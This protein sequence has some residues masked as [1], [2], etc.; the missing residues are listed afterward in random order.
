MQH[1]DLGHILI[2]V[3]EDWDDAIPVPQ[4]SRPVFKGLLPLS[5]LESL[6]CRQ[7]AIRQGEASV[8]IL[9]HYAVQFKITRV[10]IICLYIS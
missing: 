2:S 6:G 9:P 3:R 1:A 5:D 7:E 4:D 8:V 10:C